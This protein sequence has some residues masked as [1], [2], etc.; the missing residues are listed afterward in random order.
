MYLHNHKYINPFQEHPESTSSSI[1]STMIVPDLKIVQTAYHDEELER[2][3]LRDPNHNQLF[4]AL[5]S[6]KADRSTPWTWTCAPRAIDKT[7]I[8]P[9]LNNAMTLPPDPYSEEIFKK[10]YIKKPDYLAQG[11]SLF[12]G[13]PPFVIT[14][15]EISNCEYI[16]RYPHPNI[17]AYHGVLPDE[18]NLVCGLLFEKFDLNLQEVV[19]LGS[20]F[21]A[22]NALL[23]IE[24]G[25]DHLHSIGLV[26]C[27]IKPQNI[28][29]DL[30]TGRFVVGDF[31]STH[32]RGEAIHSKWGTVGW[33][34]KRFVEAQREIDF[35]GLGLV[36]FWL[37]HKG[38]GKPEAGMK[39][40]STDEILAL[41]NDSDFDGSDITGRSTGY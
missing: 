5:K 9:A 1:Q 6:R 27:D 33:T 2:V 22:H 11:E 23:Q 15:R 36:R 7:R 12:D 13:K 38:F 8:L 3:L 39:Y 41:A 26:H 37:E 40:L 19:T 30:A 28:F 29:V 10:Y 14:E 21:D 20:H 16:R 4:Y 34:E 35:H 25:I 18:K 17:C 24:A 31:D 32:C